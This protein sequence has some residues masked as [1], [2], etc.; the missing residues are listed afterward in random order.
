LRIESI[1]KKKFI[2]PVI[3]VDILEHNI[4]ALVIIYFIFVLQ[5]EIP[6]GKYAGHQPAAD[7]KSGIMPTKP[8]QV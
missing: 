5:V 6:N 2:L 7:V 8:H 4:Y 1:P 3:I